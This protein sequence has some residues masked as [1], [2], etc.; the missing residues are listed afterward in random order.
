M[1]RDT[2]L[3]DELGVSPSANE[4]E[5]KKAYRKMSIKWHPDKNPDNKEEATKNFQN[6]SE[7]YSILSDREKRQNYDQFGM[8]FVNNQNDGGVDPSDIFSQFF[9]NGSSPFGFNFNHGGQRQKPQEDIQLKLNVTLEQI[10]NEETVEINYSQKI[11]CKTCNGTGN[12]NKN[13]SKCTSCNGKGKKIQ[14]IRMGPM[15]QQIVQDCNVCG[16]TGEYNSIEDS[17][18]DCKGKGF[19]VK[20]KTIKLPLRN[21][22]DTGNKIQM[23]KKGHYFVDKKTDLIIIINVKENNNFKRDGSNLITQVDLELYQS[24]FGFDKVIKHLDGT[25]LH[26]SSSSKVEDGT[27]KKISGKGMPDLRTK[28]YGDMYIKFNV[29][30]PDISKLSIKE[31]ETVKDI[32]SKNSNEIELENKIKS[33]EILTEKTTLDDAFFKNH[34]DDEGSPQCVQQ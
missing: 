17:C 26:I 1:V 28:S 24:L 30:Y 7:A 14:I 6:I 21:G 20:S 3:Y 19:T 25:L 34:T 13:K 18:N 10:Y 31:I 2:K 33:G 8:D 11:Y 9:G 27:T 23:E 32:L 12:K 29:K 5:I 16:G 15:I 22:L 4:D